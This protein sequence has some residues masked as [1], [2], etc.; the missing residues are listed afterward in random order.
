MSEILPPKNET[1]PTSL[2]L[3]KKLLDC[4]NE[5]SKETGYTR[6]EVI[7]RFL[8]KGVEIHKGDLVRPKKQK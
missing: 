6:T 3:P 5:I 7:I 4:L 1:K 8:W 2:R